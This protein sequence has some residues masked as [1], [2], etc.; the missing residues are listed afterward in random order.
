MM[1][2]PSTGRVPLA[3]SHRRCASSSSWRSSYQSA[4][5]FRWSVSVR[6]RSYALAPSQSAV[7]AF[8]SPCCALYLTIAPTC[9]RTRGRARTRTKPPRAEVGQCYFIMRDAAMYHEETDT[10]AQCRT[11]NLNEELGCISCVLSDKTGTLTQN[12]MAFVATSIRGVRFGEGTDPPGKFPTGQAQGVKEGCAAVHTVARDGSVQELVTRCLPEL[13]R[14]RTQV[15]NEAGDSEPRSPSE[16][17]LKVGGGDASSYASTGHDQRQRRMSNTL[18]LDI[19]E[20]AT[21]R[22]L[23]CLALCNTVVPAVGTDGQLEY[24]ATSPDEDALVTGVAECGCRL[25]SRTPDKAVIR[26]EGAGP[27]DACVDEV[28]EVLAVLE[29]SSDRKR[30]STVCRSQATGEVIVYC[31]G[32]DSVILERIAP[33]QEHLE[34]TQRDLYTYARLGL[35]TLCVGR[36]VLAEEEWNEWAKEYKE[37]SVSL[38]NRSEKVGACAARLETNLELLGATAVEDKLQ[39]GVP[40]TIDALREA[41]I[42]VWMLTGDKLETAISIALTCSLLKEWMKLVIVRE[43][44][45]VHNP[46]DAL[47]NLLRETSRA[48][49]LACGKDVVEQGTPEGRGKMVKA[50]SETHLGTPPAATYG[51]YTAS[52]SDSEDWSDVPRTSDARTST[53]SFIM[54]EDDSEHG[55]RSKMQRCSSTGSFIMNEDEADHGLLQ[56]LQSSIASGF[57]TRSPSRLSQASDGTRDPATGIDQP[58]D[59]TSVAP[60]G[61]VIEGSAVRH[62]L[63]DDSR[64]LFHQLCTQCESVVCCRVSPLEKA[65]ITSLVKEKSPQG[66]ATLAIGDG[67]NDVPMIKH[68]HVGVGISG[69]EGMSAVLASDFALAQFAYLQRLVLVHGRQSQRRNADLVCYAFYKNIVY[70]MANFYFACYSA[71]SAQAFYPA[72][73][74]STYNMFWTSLPTI[75]V[76]IFD[77]DLS[78]KAVLQSPSVYDHVA[79]SA[80]RSVYLP[81]FAGWIVLALWHSLVVFY[82]PFLVYPGMVAADD[83]MQSGGVVLLGVVAYTIC[84][85]VVNVR[86]GMIVCRWSWPQWASIV[87]ISIALWFPFLYACSSLWGWQQRFPH[88]AGMWKYL[89]TAPG[90]LLVYTLGVVTSLL[91]DML[92][93]GAKR[94]LVPGDVGILQEIESGW[95]ANK[96]AETPKES[97]DG[98]EAVVKAAVD[99]CSTQPNAEA[100]SEPVA[101]VAPISAVAA[102]AAWPSFNSRVITKPLNAETLPATP[103]PGSPV[104][105]SRSSRSRGASL[106]KVPSFGSRLGSLSGDFRDVEFARGMRAVPG[107]RR[108]S[109]GSSDPDVLASLSSLWQRETVVDTIRRQSGAISAGEAQQMAKAFQFLSPEKKKRSKH[110]RTRTANV[111]FNRLDSSR[112]GMVGESGGGPSSSSGRSLGGSAHRRVASAPEHTADFNLRA[113]DPMDLMPSI[114]ESSRQGSQAESGEQS[115]DASGS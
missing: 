63:G 94:L 70:V 72:A 40:E 5:T 85:T 26:Y 88:M 15:S 6:H 115:P 9:A 4:C 32:A 90:W 97:G 109:R 41:G 101:P 95:L 37:A 22:F 23:E 49:T 80:M 81:R 36:R 21:R 113:V 50:P 83:G 18:H 39:E 104:R 106:P 82:V 14:T 107:R 46:A 73:L 75:A 33:A 114:T 57:P 71:F 52:G 42:Q 28:F 108:T 60:C 30:M 24:Q 38:E 17:D 111:D 112:L 105:A 48:A 29:F 89:E 103:T 93:V 47:R 1:R 56:K 68:A 77:K 78:D 92:L 3:F 51:A 31:K 99:D 64:D 86:I 11:T 110:R 96:W 53:G 91:P 34:A 12:R 43:E 25:V 8:L 10:P 54:N 79:I 76:A 69:K 20:E 19:Q 62:L 100:S 59:T 16:V 58:E 27:D 65:A 35:R 45:V 13:V 66:S 87:V 98:A 84:I 67:A 61:L 2:G 74:I 44:D 55:F 102:G 7:R